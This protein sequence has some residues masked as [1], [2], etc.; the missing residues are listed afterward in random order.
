MWIS[1]FAIGIALAIFLTVA[2]VPFGG[3]GLHPR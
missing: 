1:I 3:G 2:A